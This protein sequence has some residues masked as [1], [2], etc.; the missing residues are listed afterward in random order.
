MTAPLPHLDAII[1][2]LAD[3][4]SEHDG[5]V[6]DALAHHLQCAAILA[7]VA[8]AD[9][10]LQ[11]AGL[12]HDVASTLQPGQPRTH[13]REGADLVGGVLG[14]RV[15]WLVGHHDHAKRYLVTTDPGYRTCLSPTSIA[16]LEAQGGAMSE[17]EVAAF[18]REP[19]LDAVVELRRA[20]D[21]AKVPG[22]VVP[23]LDHW[24]PVVERVAANS[25]MRPETSSR[26]V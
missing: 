20:D 10:E 19:L 14:E 22:R 23:D 9:E 4:E 26:D 17:D 12:V 8:P 13:A 3:G 6:L 21:A 2:V 16:T 18:R 24:R 11:V 5:E 15:A 7:E 1:E 25:S